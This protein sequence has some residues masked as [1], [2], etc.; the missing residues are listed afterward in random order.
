MCGSRK[1]SYHPDEGHWNSKGHTLGGLRRQHFKR[2]Y[3]EKLEFVQGVGRGSSNKIV[4][5]P[6]G[7]QNN[8]MNKLVR[9]FFI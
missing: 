6:Y 5:E 4:G 3:E 1:Y 8:Q 7:Q 2:K 9:I